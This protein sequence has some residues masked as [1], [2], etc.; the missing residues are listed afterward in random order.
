MRL[1]ADM[2]S[3]EELLALP[4]FKGYYGSIDSGELD[5]HDSNCVVNPKM[6]GL[7][8]IE[9]TWEKT[10]KSFG[11]GTLN[12]NLDWLTNIRVVDEE[13][14]LGL[15]V[16]GS[17]LSINVVKNTDKLRGVYKQHKDFCICFN[18]YNTY[19]PLAVS[20]HFLSIKGVGGDASHT[21]K[22]QKQLTKW[23]RRLLK[24]GKV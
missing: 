1:T 15:V 7:K 18:T 23:L 2:K 10:N 6:F 4:S 13:F 5:F 9:L 3:K 24:C 19:T 22:S 16:D 14:E 21:F 20:N 17:T 8:D 11:N 12:F